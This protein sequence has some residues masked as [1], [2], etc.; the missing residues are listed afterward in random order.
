MKNQN[1]NIKYDVYVNI[2]GNET[3]VARKCTESR[4]IAEMNRQ[5]KKHGR[6]D[7][8]FNSVEDDLNYMVI[9]AELVIWCEEAMNY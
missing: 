1:S 7:V 4:A 9:N 5:A 3:C 8:K 2:N 6:P